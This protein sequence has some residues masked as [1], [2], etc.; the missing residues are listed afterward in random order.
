MDSAKKG[1]IINGLQ[2]RINFALRDVCLFF[3]F[4]LLR[5]NLEALETPS[6]MSISLFIRCLG[7]HQT[8]YVIYNCAVSAWLLEGLEAKFSDAASR[9]RLYDWAPRKT[10][11]QSSREFPWLTI[12]CV[13]P[14]IVTR[15][16]RHC[17]MTPLGEDHSCTWNS[18]E[19]CL[20][21]LFFG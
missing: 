8:V 13:L 20:M 6:W 5:D 16:H 11:Q 21:H 1:L 2:S 9:S 10:G 12:L 15:R 4:Q 17:G 18:P 14:H 19:S 3:F 7:P